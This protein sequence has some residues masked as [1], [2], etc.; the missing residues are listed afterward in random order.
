MPDMITTRRLVA[1]LFA[2][3]LLS[4]RAFCQPSAISVADAKSLVSL[5]LRHERINLSSRYCQLEQLDTEGKPFVA[6]YYSF[7]ASCD[8]PNT[9][10]TTPFGI[11]VVSPRT[12]DVW[13]FNRC[14]WFAFPELRRLQRN[15]MR[16]THATEMEESKYREKTGCVQ[17]K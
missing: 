5:V 8:Y 14:R 13:E 9:G 2:F 16:R 11:Y 7:G 4:G 6:D 10:A 17:G 12:G 15:I 1:I 3:L